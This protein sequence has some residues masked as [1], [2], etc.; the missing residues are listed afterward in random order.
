[1][2]LDLAVFHASR[3][4][5]ETPEGGSLPTVP[6]DP[7]AV[8]IT[9]AVSATAVALTA[10]GL[11]PSDVHMITIE[12]AMILAGYAVGRSEQPPPRA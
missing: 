1:M 12:L 8:T 3:T 7:S 4:R 9:L 2:R 11:D 5:P 6:N 10:L